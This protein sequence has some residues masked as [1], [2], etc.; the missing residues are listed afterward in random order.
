MSAMIL[1]LAALVSHATPLDTP[2]PADAL[3]PVETPGAINPN[4][5]Q[6][7]TATLQGGI[8][9]QNAAIQAQ[10]AAGAAQVA[11]LD[12]VASQARHDAQTAQQRAAAILARPRTGNTCADADA[13]ILDAIH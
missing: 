7:N 10:A 11:R 3:P 9:R 12:Q 8:D 5:T 2:V 13:A 4:V 1:L 6:A